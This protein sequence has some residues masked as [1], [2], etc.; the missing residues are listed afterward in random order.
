MAGKTAPHGTYGLSSWRETVRR[1][2]SIA[3]RNKPGMWLVSILRNASLFGHTPGMD[4]PLDVEVAEGVKA[5][6][7]PKSNRCE[8]R[9]VPGF[10]YGIRM[11]G[12]FWI[13][14]FQITAL[15]TRS[16]FSILVPMSG[17]IRC[18]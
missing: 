12:R 15:T 10:R 3:P 8:K 18:L 17:C 11:R 4:G 1:M 2:A 5:R 13:G 9:A 16:C 14:Q 7:Y 6:L